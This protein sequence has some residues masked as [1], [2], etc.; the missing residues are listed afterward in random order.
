MEH[1]TSEEAFAD[2]IASAPV[3]L[4]FFTGPG[5]GVCDALKPVAAALL[6]EHDVPGV[7]VDASALRAVAGQHLVFTVPTLI[8]F[9]GGREVERLSRHVPL[10]ALRGALDRACR[11][12][13]PD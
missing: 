13:A 8:F 2:A 5:C 7:T 9:S 12:R 3:V 4:A 1:V 10:R 6:A 11:T